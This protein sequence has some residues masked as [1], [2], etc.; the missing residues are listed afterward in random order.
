MSICFCP[1]FD[2]N[3]PPRS[4]SSCSQKL[5][6]LTNWSQKMWSEEEDTRTA[7]W[8]HWSL[9]KLMRLTKPNSF[10]VITSHEASNLMLARRED[11]LT[12]KVNR[13]FT[14]SKVGLVSRW[15]VGRRPSKCCGMGRESRRLNW[16][17]CRFYEE[18]R[19]SMRSSLATKYTQNWLLTL[20]T[21]HHPTYQ[22][23]W[24]SSNPIE[25]NTMEGKKKPRFEICLLHTFTLSGFSERWMSHFVNNSVYL[26]LSFGRGAR[27][28]GGVKVC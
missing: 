14:S 9:A 24:H 16:S 1:Y 15:W 10:L 3:S 5:R 18:N 23:V 27:E 19:K 21:I 2:F 13:C 28:V 22:S 8:K 6:R 20:H 25:S 17:G 11:W 26:A 7:G 12:R 4:R